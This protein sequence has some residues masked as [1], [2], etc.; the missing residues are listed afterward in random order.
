MFR[1]GYLTPWKKFTN[2]KEID[3]AFTK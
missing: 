1:K 2:D 3:W